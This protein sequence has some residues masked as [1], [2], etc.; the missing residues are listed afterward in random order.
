MFGNVGKTS[1]KR[2]GLILEV[3]GEIGRRF[4]EETWIW[5]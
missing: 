1:L 3:L 2:N 5:C 4:G